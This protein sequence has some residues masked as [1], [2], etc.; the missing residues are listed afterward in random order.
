MAGAVYVFRRSGTSWAQEAYVKASN[1][2]T[3]G[4]FGASVALQDN[5]LVVGAP[6]EAGGSSGLNGDQADQSRPLSGAAYVFERNGNAWSQVSYVKTPTSEFGAGFGAS[7]ALKGKT[8][9]L[10]APGQPQFGAPGYAG[11]VYVY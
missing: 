11:K 10:G 4:Q 9:A 8:L 5:T 7:V 6:G 2:V 1:T 3:F